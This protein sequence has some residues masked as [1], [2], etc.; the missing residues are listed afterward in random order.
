[1][2]NL[3][4]VSTLLLFILI[5]P[6]HAN[7]LSNKYYKEIKELTEDVI[8]DKISKEV[9]KNTVNIMGIGQGLSF[10]SGVIIS[11]SKNYTYVI[12]CKHCVSP[13]EET[14]IENIP[15]EAIFAPMDEDLA[16]IIIKGN[17]PEKIT[18][19]LSKDNPQIK[20]ELIH[21]GYPKFKL[22]ES[23]GKLIRTSKDWHWATFSAKS[24]CSGGG[25]YNRKKELVGI[26]WGSLYYGNISIY[27][28]I[29]DIHKFL[30]KVKK[31]IK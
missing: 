26:L 19:I 10:C 12:T 28:P 20:E 27:E 7:K 1:M 17:I 2:K 14:L 8:K 11:S 5:T 22:H 16:L 25:V 30:K 21:I 13:T 6:S 23:W 3:W 9:Q 15:A 31:Y 4:L 29:E 18:A 24:G